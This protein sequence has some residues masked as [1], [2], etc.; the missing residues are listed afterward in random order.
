MNILSK[1]FPSFLWKLARHR[2]HCHF[3]YLAVW[4]YVS[5]KW[6]TV[7]PR[8]PSEVSKQKEKSWITNNQ[9]LE[10]AFLSEELSLPKSV[11]LFILFFFSCF[12]HT[13]YSGCLFIIQH[14]GKNH[15]AVFLVQI[16]GVKTEDVVCCTDCLSPW[17]KFVIS[18]IGPYKLNWLDYLRERLMENVYLCDNGI[19]KKDL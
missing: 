3:C 12:V 14:H 19:Y 11:I 1:I 6:S 9:R 8:S 17:D 4:A 16:K 2:C 7:G 5:R 10:K 15:D 13:T 18:D